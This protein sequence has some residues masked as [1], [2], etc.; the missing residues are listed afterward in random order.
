MLFSTTCSS[1]KCWSCK[2]YN[3]TGKWS[4]LGGG[5]NS[6]VSTRWGST[7]HGVCPIINNMCSLT[8]C[9]CPHCW[10]MCCF[11]G[12]GIQPVRIHC[13]SLCINNINIPGVAYYLD[14]PWLLAYVLFSRW[15]R[16]TSGR[17]LL[18]LLTLYLLQVGT[19]ILCYREPQGQDSGEVGGWVRVNTQGQ[20]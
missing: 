2:F 1:W 4:L 18:F 6:Q 20:Y 11:P 17:M 9:V 10:H 19:A 5:L 8:I 15:W 16:Q 3:T 12:G 7:L 14:L 13:M